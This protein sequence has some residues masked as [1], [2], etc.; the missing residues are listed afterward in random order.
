MKDA[1]QSTFPFPRVGFIGLGHMGLPMCTHLII[2]G[3]EVVAHNRSM[4]SVERVSAAGAAIA[5]TP[6]AVAEA[7]GDGVIFLC[8]TNTELTNAVVEGTPAMPGLAAGLEPGALVIDCGS[9]GVAKT[10][11]WHLLARSHGAAWLDAPLSGGVVGAEQATL[12]VMC[13]GEG[14]AFDRALPLLETFGE[15]IE[16]LGPSGAGQIAK[17]A[18]QIIVASSIA[19]ISEAFTLARGHTLDLAAMRRALLG[20]FAS[21]RVLDLHGRRMIDGDFAPGGTLENQVKDLNAALALAEA[22]GLTLP[23]LEENKRI[24]QSALESGLGGL[25]HSAL[26]KHYL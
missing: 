16:L 1:L 10:R 23:L 24:W 18:N 21:S 14:E 25:D 17:L 15:V 11:E 12:T 2:A 26:Y 13:G 5:G 8:L 20:G 19:A 7:V 3:C 4:A 22:D 6:A 9:N